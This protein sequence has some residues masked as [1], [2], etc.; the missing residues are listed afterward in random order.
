MVLNQLI[1]KYSVGFVLL[2]IFS[3]F[4]ASC[5]HGVKETVSI[6]NY[7]SDLLSIL[8]Q[9]SDFSSNW[10]WIYSDISQNE[11]I[12][13]NENNYIIEKAT[14]GLTGLYGEERYYIMLFHSLE[15]YQE[16]PM[17]N[18]I[19]LTEKI[20]SVDGFSLSIDQSAVNCTRETNINSRNKIVFCRVTVN[21]N[22]LTSIITIYAPAS[23]EDE[24]LEEI[25]TQ[26]LVAVSQR[27]QDKNMH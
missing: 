3:T 2:G 22:T 9:P 21:Y 15:K 16:E 20:P 11:E 6:E 8:I 5:K 24:V 19:D 13:T 17:K 12:P 10:Q 26:A 27:V 23:I 4:L 14:R 18:S 7:D 1:K 25:L